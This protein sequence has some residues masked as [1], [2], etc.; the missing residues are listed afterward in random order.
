MP[1]Q[2]RNIAAALVCLLAS[3]SAAQALEDGGGITAESQP[4]T[5][6]DVVA[7]RVKA[8]GTAFSLSRTQ[9]W[10]SG[11]VPSG[12]PAFTPSPVDRT[13]GAK[14]QPFHDWNFLIGTELTRGGGEGGFLSS[15][16]MWE[17]SWSQDVERFGGLT[18]GLSTTG[19][20]SNAQADYL[21]SF[22]GSLNLPLDLPLNAWNLELRF[23]PNMNL[24][25]SKGALSSNLMSEL[26]GQ[27]VLS[28]QNGAFRSVLDVSVGYNLAP[29]ARP[30]ASARMQLTIS[31]KL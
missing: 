15:K 28:P 29:D 4:W 21:Q 18:F 19:S 8:P 20:V 22:S 24:D 25:V 16:A 10:A 9:T 2:S 27:T 11:L 3:A 17:S 7:R 5:I 13:L 6:D 12:I 31:P 14:L 30:A 23:S 1:F 26:V